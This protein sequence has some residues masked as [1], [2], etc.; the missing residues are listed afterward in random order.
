MNKKERTMVDKI[1]IHLDAMMKLGEEYTSNLT[2]P[3]TMGERPDFTKLLKEVMI[4]EQFSETLREME[5]LHQILQMGKE[6]IEE[7]C[8]EV[9]KS[10]REMAL[11]IMLDTIMK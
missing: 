11:S 2:P 9:G 3:P 6:D 10:P 1:E 7:S 5:I 4:A 8:R